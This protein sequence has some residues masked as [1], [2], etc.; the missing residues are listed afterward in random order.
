MNLT[1]IGVSPGVA[2][3]PV[4][5][6]SKVNV[7]EL[8][9]ASPREVFAALDNVAS[10]LEISAESA[11]LDVVKDVLSAQAMI[12]R[13]PA[14]IEAI[15]ARLT[16]DIE[17]PDVR[18]AITEAFAGFRLAL[19]SLGGYFAERVAKCSADEEQGSD[20]TTFKTGAD[21]DCCE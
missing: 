7:T 20:F 1:G 3:G 14:L 6:I 19:E 13:D 12:A 11:K 5:K 4:R 21:C 15:G 9:P 18:P 8:I 10:D 17:Y 2:V 16:D